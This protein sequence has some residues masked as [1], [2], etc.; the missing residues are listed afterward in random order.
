[1]HNMWLVGCFRGEYER[2]VGI[3]YGGGKAGPRDEV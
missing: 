3:G 2:E 1:M